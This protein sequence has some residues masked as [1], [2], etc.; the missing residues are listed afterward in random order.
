M[1]EMSNPALT[2]PCALFPWQLAQLVANNLLPSKSA[3]F[4]F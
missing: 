3:L 2:A 4:E 1:M